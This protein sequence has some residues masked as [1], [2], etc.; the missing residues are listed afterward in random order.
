M[1]LEFST[2]IQMKRLSYLVG[3]ALLVNAFGAV[4]K[5]KIRLL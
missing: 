4:E 2:L 5:R 1:P 3:F